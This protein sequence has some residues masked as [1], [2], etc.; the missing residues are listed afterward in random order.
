MRFNS[1]RLLQALAGLVLLMSLQARAADYTADFNSTTLD[2]GSQVHSFEQGVWQPGV[3]APWS[4][5]TGNGYLSIAKSVSEA[6]NPYPDGPH[7][8]TLVGIIGDFVATV[9]ADSRGNGSGG[10]GF[11]FDSAYGFSG[12]SFGTNWLG[13]S[14]GDGYLNSGFNTVST[15]VVTLQIQRIGDTLTKSYQLD[16]QAGFTTFSTLSDAN[17]PGWAWFDLTNY[18]DQLDATE[19]LF[20]NFS[21]VQLNVSA[22]PE[23]QAYAMLLA[24]L[25][26]VGVLSRRR[27]GAPV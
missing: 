24:G 18:S 9:T 3:V 2:P 5:T 15:P 14:A 23:P 26:L 16:G 27:R 17:V 7:V 22:V 8:Q 25:A 10:A 19:V 4:L 20:S 13:D 1:T 21:V 6:G 12:I 11:F